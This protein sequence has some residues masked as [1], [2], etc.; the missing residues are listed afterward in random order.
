MKKLFFVSASLVLLSTQ[1]MAQVR[2]GDCRPVFPVVDQVAELPP[3]PAVVTPPPP[4]VQKRRY[5]A[6]WLAGGFVILAGL[7]VITH[8]HNHHHNNPVSPA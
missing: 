3:P 6:A 7:I 8:D 5:D 1:A 4:V 2:P